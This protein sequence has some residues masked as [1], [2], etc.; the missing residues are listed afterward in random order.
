MPDQ[1]LGSTRILGAVKL[2]RYLPALDPCPEPDGQGD[3]EFSKM[4]T[5]LEELVVKEGEA[6][7]Y[8]KRAEIA[9]A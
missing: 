6:P 8:V 3:D 1:P 7:D 9:H 4:L 2:S 5:Q